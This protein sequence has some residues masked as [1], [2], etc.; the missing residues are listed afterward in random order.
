ME[1]LH[2]MYSCKYSEMNTQDLS[3]LKSTPRR[4]RGPRRGREPDRAGAGFGAF[5]KEATELLDVQDESWLREVAMRSIP[6]C[7]VNKQ[8]ENC[9]ISLNFAVATRD[10][11]QDTMQTGLLP[12]ECKVWA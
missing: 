4:P 8:N 9:R 7:W 1:K 11:L 5:S 6:S 12:A 2:D 3:R 10:T